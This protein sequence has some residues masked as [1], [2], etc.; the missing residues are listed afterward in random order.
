MHFWKPSFSVA[1]LLRTSTLPDVSDA[2]QQKSK[3]Q[4][5]CPAA[6]KERP[7][8]AVLVDGIQQPS[9]GNRRVKRA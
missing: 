9:G 1:G 4:Q 5:K 6:R 8:S 7:R 3:P 2:G